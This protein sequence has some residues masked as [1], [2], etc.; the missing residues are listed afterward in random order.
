MNS[1]VAGKSSSSIITSEVDL[2]G[3]FF[4]SPLLVQRSQN[5][6]VF[7]LNFPIFTSEGELQDSSSSTT[8]FSFFIFNTQIYD[9]FNFSIPSFP[10]FRRKNTKQIKRAI[11]KTQ[12]E[13]RKMKYLI[14][15][16][17]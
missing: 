3:R 6:R 8:I 1:G 9:R 12:P 4:L 7:F 2:G 11:E 15:S 10:V 5:K 17:S 16:C 13:V 14:I